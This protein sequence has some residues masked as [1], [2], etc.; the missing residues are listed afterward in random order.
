MHVLLFF[1]AT[2]DLE[3]T[4]RR[5]DLLKAQC[6]PTFMIF[7]AGQDGSYDPVYEGLELTAR[8]EFCK[9]EEPE[10][11][12]EYNEIS[13]SVSQLSVDLLSESS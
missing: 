2:R 3:R 10:F 12:D 5:I 13:E 11:S 1:S 8:C 4:R 7:M 6:N 9:D